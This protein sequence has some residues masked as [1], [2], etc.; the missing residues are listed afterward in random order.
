M[1]KLQNIQA[2]NDAEVELIKR[3]SSLLLQKKSNGFNG[4]LRTSG[5]IVENYIKG[6]ISKHIPYG[7]RICSGYIATVDTI[8]DSDNLIQHDLV[9]IDSR[10]PSLY[11]FGVSDIE[12]VSAESV[13][14]V[15]EIKR[16][17]TKDSLT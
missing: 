9:I 10:I 11:T 13:C 5:T 14:G 2:V 12:I 7:Y 6:I 1:K 8:N 15:I 4:E 16:T 3:Q 17:L